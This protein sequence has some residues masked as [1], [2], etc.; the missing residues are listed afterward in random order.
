MSFVVCAIIRLAR[1]RQ[2]VTF[3]KWWDMEGLPLFLILTVLLGAAF[4]LI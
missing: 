3:G 2:A 1:Q 4:H